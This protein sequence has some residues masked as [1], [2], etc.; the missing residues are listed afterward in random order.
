MQQLEADGELEREVEFLPSAE[1][2][3]RASRATA[4]GMVRPELAVLLAY[5]KRA[6]AAA[7]LESDLPDS[8]Y[9]GQ[10]L[11][12]VLPAGGRRAVRPPDRRAPAEAGADRDD[13]GERRRE[14]RR[15][16]TFVSR[17][18]DGDRR[19]RPRRRARVPH[20]ARR[21]GRRRALGRHRSA[22]R[23]DRPARAER[24]DDAASTGWWRPRRAGT[25]C[26]ATGQRLSEAIGGAQRLVRGALRRDRSDRP[27]GLARGARTRRRGAS[28]PK[29]CRRRSRA[30]TRSRASWCTDPTSSRS[31]T[32]RAGRSC[33]VARGFFL[34]GER[35]QLDWLEQQLEAM[36][37]GTRWQRW[38][39][40][41]MED[42]L[43]TLR[44]QL[45]ETVAGRMRPRCRSTRRSRRSCESRADAV[46][47]GCSGSCSG[48]PWKG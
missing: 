16:I 47:A 40:Q 21:H 1:E 15:A 3:L 20:R 23:R 36:P 8:P 35:L 22:R 31:P 32:R 6:I 12:A 13:R 46:R 34:L 4:Q 11:R 25:W 33:E 9:L 10:D 39:Q 7:L 18:I 24:A 28:W 43:F 44:R 30:G 29:A 38:A 19:R 14:L 27:R 5:A 26:S 17:M 42:D 37:A 45:A 2:M 41:S 48:S